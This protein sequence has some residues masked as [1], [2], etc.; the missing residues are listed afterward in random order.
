ME[1]LRA[2]RNAVSIP[3]VA[4]GGINSGNIMRLAGGGVGRSCRSFRHL[5][6]TASREA[7][8]GMLKLAEE[9]LSAKTVRGEGNE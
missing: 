3:I 6:R 5:R 7:T 9:M 2:I 8:A 4:I 1:Q